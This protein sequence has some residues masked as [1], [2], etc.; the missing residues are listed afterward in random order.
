[1][2][3]GSCGKR[4]KSPS[5]PGPVAAGPGTKM[6]FHAVSPTGVETPYRT[7]FEA[8]AAARKGGGGWEV[9]GRRLK[10]D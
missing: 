6:I 10:V 5:D 1:M 9:A 7:L 2:A 3:C 8:R 4:R